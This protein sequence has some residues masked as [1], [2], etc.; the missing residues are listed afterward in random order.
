MLEKLGQVIYV[1]KA[2]TALSSKTNLDFF[3]MST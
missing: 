3:Y 2:G 1:Y